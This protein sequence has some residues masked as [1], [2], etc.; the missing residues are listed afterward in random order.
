MKQRLGQRRWLWVGGLVTLLLMLPAAA[1]AHP[2]GNFT[3]SRYSR[4]TLETEQIRLRY[5]V[6]MAEIPTFQSRAEIDADSDGILSSAERVAYLDDQIEQWG[7][8]LHLR[9]D[10]RRLPLTVQEKSLEFQPGQG[11]LETLRLTADFVA[12]LPGSDAAWQVDYQ[13]DTFAGRLGWQEIVVEPMAG[14][15]LLTA[16][17]PTEDISEA[18]SRYPD[19]L[20]QSPLAINRVEFRFEPGVTNHHSTTTATTIAPENSGFLGREADQFAALITLPTPGP[21]TL[22]VALLAAF[23]WGAAHAL[24]PGHGKTIVAAYLVGSRGTVGH[25][26]FL[27]LTTTLTHTA[28]VFILGLLTLFASQFILPEQL[29]PWL[30]VASGLLVVGIGLSLFRGRLV[31][32]LNGRPTDHHHHHHHDHDHHHHDHDHS[33]PHDHHHGHSHVPDGPI[34]WRSLLALGISG[35]LI[36][37]P[38]ALVV[39]LSAIALQRIGFGLLLVITFSLGLAGVLTIIGVLWVQ[40]THLL[41]R[42]SRKTTWFERWP[43]QRRWLQILP[44]AS[45]L[46]ITL[47]GLG[48]TLQALTQTGWLNL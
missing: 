38:S 16:D 45:A 48:I 13:D 31:S 39:M 43:G 37:C 4:L 47:V 11:G 1:L 6:D 26:V 34:T 27:G 9:V 17:V 21:L 30:G 14:I 3:I 12:R 44:A 22:L 29:Y 28:G 32:L 8:T 35:G 10:G 25:A 18:L 5:I 41:E 15:T 7:D 46:F 19:D 20:L 24:T 33:H 42:L 40:A 23:G 2:L 36:P